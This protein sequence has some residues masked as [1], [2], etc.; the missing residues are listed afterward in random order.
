M[1][2]RKLFSLFSFLIISSTASTFAAYTI[3]RTDGGNNTL[4]V[5]GREY[6]YIITN[7]N[8]PVRLEDVT[9]DMN[10]SN[11]DILVPP[12]VQTGPNKY[13]VDSS[14]QLVI[15]IRFHVAASFSMTVKNSQDANN[16]GTLNSI[17][18]QRFPV[19][20]SITPSNPTV[21]ADVAFNID[22]TA[23][24]SQGV[25]VTAYEDP[26]QI[27]D[28]QLDSLVAFVNGTSFSNGTAQNVP[29][30]VKAGDL[31]N[32]FRLTLT[33]TQQY[34]NPA[35]PTPSLTP[36]PTLTTN[37][38]NLIPGAFFKL[39][40]TFPGEA[41]SPG[42]GKVGAPSTQV[43]GVPVSLVEVRRVDQFFNPIL[44]NP[45]PAV[46]VQ[47]TSSR[48]PGTD[49]PPFPFNLLMSG[50]LL[51]INSAMNQ[52]FFGGSGSA[53]IKAIPDSD[54]SKEDSSTIIVNAGAAETYEIAII[55]VAPNSTITTDDI[56]R[57]E[58]TAKDQNG[59]PLTGLIGPVS[60]AELRA[61]LGTGLES[62]DWVDTNEPTLLPNNVISF[63]T[64]TSAGTGKAVMNLVVTKF[65]S[66]VMLHY[67]T[68]NR[69]TFSIPFNVDPG[70]ANK[71]HLTIKGKSP[72][73]TQGESWTPGT[74]PGNTGTP[75]TVKVGE[76]VVVEA[77]ITDKR[78]NLISGGGN[79][80]SMQLT[81]NLQQ[82]FITARHV[83]LAGP[84]YTFPINGEFSYDSNAA[85]DKS[86]RVAFRTAGPS[87]IVTAPRFL[88]VVGNLPGG[89]P[90]GTFASS[91]C[92]INPEVYSKLVIVAPGETLR[93]GIENDPDG[94][95]ENNGTG[96][97]PQQAG[98]QFNVAVHA[99]D[100]YFNPI[101]N[102]PFPTVNF[103]LT[104]SLVGTFVSGTLPSPLQSGSKN[105]SVTLAQTTDVKVLDNSNGA[106]NQTVSIPV[107]H[108][109]LAHFRMTL[110]TLGN[111]E[112]GVLFPVTITAEDQ[113][114]NTVLT[115]NS[116]VTL[117]PNT[118][119]GTMSPTSV[120]LN[121]G[122]FNG[123]LKMF[124]ANT[125]ANIRMTFGSV[126]SLSPNFTVIENSEGYKRLLLLLPGENIA[127]GTAAGK[128]GTPNSHNV[129]L[130]GI[131]IRAIACDMYYNPLSATGNVGFI[132]NHH[133]NFSA[134]Q[135]SLQ[136][137][138]NGYSEFSAVVTLRTATT[139]TLEARDVNNDATISRS[140]SLIQATPGLYKEVQIVVPGESIDPGTF[141]P[142]GKSGSPSPQKVATPFTVIINAV[143]QFWNV[144][145]NK[146]DGDIVLNSLTSAVIFNPPNNPSGG[147]TPRP[148]ANGT[149]TREIIIGQQGTTQIFAVEGSKQ[150]KTV[151]ISVNPG[152]TYVF[153]TP[154][155]A[156][157]G[158]PFA[159][160][161]ITLEENGVPVN[162]FNRSIFL[163][164]NMTSGGSA[165][166]AFNPDGTKRE[167]VMN[168]GMVVINDLSYAYSEAIK[169]KVEDE[170]A[171]VG[172]SNSIDVVPSGL[173][174]QIT[175]PAT[176][177]AGPPASFSVKIELLDLNTS[178]LVKNHDHTVDIDILS[179]INPITSGS[180][181]IPYVTL[182][183]GVAT[184]EQSYSKAESVVINISESA[185][186]GEPTY[187]VAV[188]NSN[189]INIAPDSYKKLLILLPGE[190]HV[191]GVPSAT[192][193]TGP[194]FA[195]QKGIPFFVQVRGVDQ[196]WNQI[197][198]LNGGSVNFASNDLLP[199]SLGPTNPNNQD[200]ALVAG[201]TASY[202]TLLHPGDT[203]ITVKD[204]SDDLIGTQS[205]LVK[206][207]GLYYKVDNVPAETFAG[208]QGAFSMNVILYDSNT[209]LPVTSA[210]NSI[211][212]EAMYPDGTTANGFLGVTTS[213][214]S[215]GN[216]GISNQTYSIAED[217]LINVKDANGNSGSNL[218]V[219]KFIPR[220][221]RYTFETPPDATVNTPFIVTIKT[222][223][224]DTETEVKNFSRTNTLE[225][226]SAITGTAVAGNFVPNSVNIVNGVGQV[227]AVY[228]V[229]EAIFLKM[230]DATP[231]NAKSPPTQSVFTSQGIINVH[232]GALDSI[233][234]IADF[235]MQ[236]NEIQNFTLIAKDAYG[237]IIPNQTLVIT[238]NSIQEPG[239]IFLNGQSNLL[240]A[241]TNGQGELALT[242]KPSIQT[243]GDVELLFKD[244][245]RVNGFTRLINIKMLG[246][247]LTP[248]RALTLGGDR[249]PVNSH[250]QLDINLQ[251]QPGAQL[252]TFYRLDGGAWQTYDPAAGLSGLDQ[253]KQYTVEWY[254]K[255]CYD[256]ACTNALSTLDINGSPNVML[257]TTYIVDEHI[258]GYPSPFNPKNSSGDNFL[259]IQYP[260]ATA[261]SVAIDI[262]DL[263]G[264][265]VWHTDID[266]GQ[267]GAMAKPDNRIFWFG[268]NNDG[269]TVANGGYIVVVKAGSQRM[270]TK[271]LVVK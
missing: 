182:S 137:N 242:I 2:F 70:S 133:A 21:N 52:I 10:N 45:N 236:S 211:T 146:N 86:F 91:T 130:G 243:N 46:D 221:V 228:N 257:L 73:P 68:P 190:T 248:A 109:P 35:L 214:L 66:D 204:L 265:K 29:V 234:G 266:A 95:T 244:G 1:N 38:L 28:S 210:N 74:Y 205:A 77:R 184:L 22:V 71:V 141:F 67:V 179:A 230:T 189:P 11:F 121:A 4:L 227:S 169:I 251:V 136:L 135:G 131:V 219:I 34:F 42:V 159:P 148:F 61:R 252:Q 7:T 192:G 174:Y 18:V 103:T 53:V 30:T 231:P 143:D 17:Q 187:D 224:Q 13:A 262:Y 203:A 201:E 245:D 8:V 60:G 124:A 108:G 226:F 183:Q 264:Q 199:T 157:A 239:A 113:Y 144:I 79:G 147:A 54:Q 112:A 98:I 119:A 171:R 25:V 90:A 240:T 56:I 15:S 193:K 24:D 218:N 247:T 126:S 97:T 89:S 57:V 161:T 180:F 49:A 20:F 246:L 163:S 233:T 115:F 116:N 186:D 207:G 120:A 173:K 9:I 114:N 63:N 12:G 164:A 96:P 206:V 238:V 31:N 153:Q 129:D 43:S 117:T 172:F 83:T 118:G 138:S 84:S 33:G 212:L 26:V 101:V 253:T 155:T 176:A 209:N 249:I 65:G 200:A 213:Q 81:N 258:S 254:T 175:V 225:A 75:P 261:A 197:N 267:E 178:T 106:I 181:T 64:G 185:T 223:D 69:E 150:S 3:T 151:D 167:Y 202:L 14:G 58:I 166:G 132:S 140:Q 216:A 134:D 165:S 156:V 170:F 78:W 222:I 44:A 241:K 107:I 152:P 229:A 87:T 268:T 62:R 125:T 162:G 36:N 255:V 269:T 48:A 271:V 110:N 16:K 128:T 235:T 217:I 6:E 250:P 47:F 59:V 188:R 94:K 191:P 19:T 256:Q 123:D 168:N 198:T 27:R 37:F 39:V 158:Q 177:I 99:T 208:P 142:N 149:A 102:S 85:F 82:H 55:G 220:Q 237:N 41:L 122:V 260:L 76:E 23:L 93:P 92:T 80:Y 145:T 232:P 111:K 270:K 88:G 51:S 100:L 259:T 72:N 263:F 40:M 154:A 32:Q 196:Y 5:Q 215:G 139:H 50:P 127:P 195:Q 105:F 104:P 194:S 160:V